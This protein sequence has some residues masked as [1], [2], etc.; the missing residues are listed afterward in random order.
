[1]SEAPTQPDD[2]GAR[3]GGFFRRNI[4]QHRWRRIASIV[5]VAVVVLAGLFYGVGGWFFSGI[6]EEDALVVKPITSEY[7]LEVTELSEDTIT[8]KV[9]GD[10][11]SDQ[12]SGGQWDRDL[13]VGV[14]TEDTS[15]LV[16]P[17]VER[18]DE[19][20][21]RR[22]IPPKVGELEV[23]DRVTF[24][25][26]AFWPNPGR[27]LDQ[28]FE[29]VTF[30]NSLGTFPAWHTPAADD[31]VW[32]IYVH[33]KGANRVEP[34]RIEASLQEEGLTGLNIEYRND[35]GAPSVP[36][37]IARYGQTEWEDVNAAVEF[38]LDRGA[39]RF[40][41]V[42]TS[43]GGAIVLGFMERS[44]HADRVEA[45]VLDSPATDIGDIIRTEAKT[46]PLIP[47]V[48]DVGPGLTWSAMTIA[49]WRFDISWS[50][51]GY[52]DRAGD[53]DVPMLIW[54]AEHDTTVPIETIEEFVDN[55]RSDLVRFEEITD[56]Q[57]SHLMSWNVDPDRYDSVTR[58]FIREHV[59]TPAGAQTS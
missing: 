33:G 34:L 40:V 32:A 45:L 23:G 26:R 25:V 30:E 11:G 2:A 43:M 39:K 8:L 19:I 21:T 27:G 50:E 57:A 22:Y 58:A 12:M 29:S 3:Q 15:G 37:K 9:V 16:G 35:E 24:N 18:T 36:G 55:A 28:E 52:N 38:A 31:E 48:V 46:T 53:F 10:L 14:G 56:P 13:W 4:W 51:T 17:A 54:A 1:V 6:I 5:T 44:E 41:L 42:G 7:P 47:G 49:S 59:T 20:A